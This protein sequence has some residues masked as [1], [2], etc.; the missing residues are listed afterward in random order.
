MKTDDL[1]KEWY[2]GDIK[3]LIVVIRDGKGER[4]IKGGEI[5]AVRKDGF[6]LKDAFIPA[7][8]IIRIEKVF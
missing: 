3:K 5:T 7:H 1:I 8:R 2:Y 6:Y 4:K